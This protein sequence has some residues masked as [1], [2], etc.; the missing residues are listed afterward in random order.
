MNDEPGHEYQKHETV[1][2]LG[3]DA[4]PACSEISG[5]CTESMLTWIHFSLSQFPDQ[6]R[7]SEE[8]SMK[9][10]M[11]AFCAVREERASCCT[12]RM[13]IQLLMMQIIEKCMREERKHSV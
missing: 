13:M 8:R 3:G 12:F 10:R 1:Y 5:R 9:G 7:E 6:Q 2:I 11:S 4:G